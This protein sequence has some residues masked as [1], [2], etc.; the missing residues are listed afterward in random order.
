MA[1][2]PLLEASG[3]DVGA[4]RISDADRAEIVQLTRELVE[5]PSATKDL[6]ANEQCLRYIEEYLKDTDWVLTRF[7]KAPG[8]S[9][10]LYIA[11]TPHTRH[12]KLLFLGHADVVPARTYSVTG[13]AAAD[14]VS[15]ISFLCPYLQGICFARTG[16][17]R[18]VR[19]SST[20]GGVV[21][22][23]CACDKLALKYSLHACG[24]TALLQG[25]LR[26]RS[27]GEA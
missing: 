9:P 1:G 25:T 15:G 12:T 5:I 22:Y 11:P 19:S 6:V 3:K 13:V 2:P 23:T 8:M 14:L 16:C 20:W 21:T 27:A 4:A 10:A 18:S 7:Q 17:S 24:G 26:V